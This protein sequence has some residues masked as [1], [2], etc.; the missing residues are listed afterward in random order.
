MSEQAQEISR[1]APMINLAAQETVVTEEPMRIHEVDETEVSQ[2]DNEPLERPD[3]YPEKFW[4]EDGPD[5]EK[6]AK[7]YSELEKAFKAGKHK[8]P[9]NGYKTDDLVN[10]GLD[11]EDPTVQVYQEWAQ[12]YGISQ[13]AFEELASEVL[14]LTGDAEEEID[15]DRRQE[16]E[17]LGERATEKISFLE[18]HL[19]KASLTNAEREALA[20]SFNS[21]DAINAMVKFIQGY[22]NEGIPTQPVVSA[23]EFTVDDLQQAISDP[24]WLTDDVWRSKIEKQWMAAN[25]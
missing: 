22:T 24:R 4:G 7:S 12:K 3:F 1:D 9:E 16:M 23:S 21:A 19:T 17:K 25:S 13:Q 14:Q 20:Y 8:A 15:Y 18:R 2:E 11:L 5:I 6:L 10:R